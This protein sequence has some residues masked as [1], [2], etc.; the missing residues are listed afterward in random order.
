M[1][2]DQS[3]RDVDVSRVERRTPGS[4]ESKVH[5]DP[6]F[7]GNASGISTPWDGKARVASGS[8]D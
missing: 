2:G 8:Y 3:D 4:P 6:I 7:F 5:S 1:T